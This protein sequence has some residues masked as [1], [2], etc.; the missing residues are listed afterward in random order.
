MMLSALPDSYHELSGMGLRYMYSLGMQLTIR[1]KLPVHFLTS[2]ACIVCY[3]IP[4]AN[5]IQYLMA[6]AKTKKG[7]TQLHYACINRHSN[8]IRF[9]TLLNT[10]IIKR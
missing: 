9:T 3:K 10:K 2:A 1:Q 5:D 8:A 7:Q 4:V 6:P